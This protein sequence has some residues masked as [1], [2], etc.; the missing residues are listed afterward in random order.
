MRPDGTERPVEHQPADYSRR[1]RVTKR[2]R[3]RLVE[4]QTHI[5]KDEQTDC[6]NESDES[7]EGD[8]RYQPHEIGCRA[9]MCELRG[10]VHKRSCG[11]AYTAVR[12]SA[13]RRRL[14][15]TEQ[16]I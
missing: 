11:H 13:R 10:D 14:L 5:G 3:P 1:Y 16:F 8:Q 4:A 9:P 7:D 6:R 15:R 2:T 12:V